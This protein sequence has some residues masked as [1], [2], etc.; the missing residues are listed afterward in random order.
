MESIFKNDGCLGIEIEKINRYLEKHGLMPDEWFLDD[1][2]H[3]C[4][5]F[6]KRNRCYHVAIFGNP[7]SEKYYI[8]IKCGFNITRLNIDG[9]I[10]LDQHPSLNEFIDAVENN[11]IPDLTR[12]KN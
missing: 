5:W 7:F 4:S 2:I 9:F 10:P 12:N 3:L 6:R 8:S 11:E 1:T